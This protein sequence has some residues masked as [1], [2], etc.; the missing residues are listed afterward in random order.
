MRTTIFLN[1]IFIALNIFQG[2]TWKHAQ[3]D[4]PIRNERTA[5]PINTGLYAP[6][7]AIKAQRTTALAGVGPP[8]FLGNLES[9][10]ISESVDLYVYQELRSFCP[11]VAPT[12]HKHAFEDNFLDIDA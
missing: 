7:I 12:G 3:E 5:R 8:L 1:G 10:R 11:A 9:Q 4:D 6:E 2:F